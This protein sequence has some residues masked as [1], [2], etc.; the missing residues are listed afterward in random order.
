[1]GDSHFYDDQEYQGITEGPD[2]TNDDVMKAIPL[3]TKSSGIGVS[4]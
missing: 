2:T 3:V 1:M 4:D